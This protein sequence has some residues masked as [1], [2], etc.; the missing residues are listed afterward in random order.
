MFV[1]VA[2]SNGGPICERKTGPS[3]AAFLPSNRL[4]ADVLRLQTAMAPPAPTSELSTRL[5]LAA[6][7]CRAER[8]HCVVV[9]SFP[10]HGGKMNNWS[11]S[12]PQAPHT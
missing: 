12:R 1:R 10:L 7:S 2:R 9:F 3:L 4:T 8:E 6:A 5:L 11:A